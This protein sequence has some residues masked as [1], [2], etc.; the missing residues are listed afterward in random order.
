MRERENDEAGRSLFQAPGTRGKL[1][2]WE[3]T[4]FKARK[5]K[6]HTTYVDALRRDSLANNTVELMTLMLDRRVWRA[7]I[8][9]SRVGVG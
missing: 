9:E 6:K 3:P 2:L 4:L 7:T 1:T 5:G 8:Q